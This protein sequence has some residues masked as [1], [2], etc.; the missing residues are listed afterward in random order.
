MWKVVLIVL[1][2]VMV[3]STWTITDRSYSNFLYGENLTP[4]EVLLFGL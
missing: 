3:F 4:D 2:L 1:T